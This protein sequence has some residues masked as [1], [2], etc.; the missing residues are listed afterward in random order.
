MKDS[1]SSHQVFHYLI[2]SR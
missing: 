2:I 1:K